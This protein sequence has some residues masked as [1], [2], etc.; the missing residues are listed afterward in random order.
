LQFILIRILNN[1]KEKGLRSVTVTNLNKDFSRLPRK[2]ELTQLRLMH[3]SVRALIRNSQKDM[4]PLLSL[5]SGTVLKLI[6]D[7]SDVY[8]KAIQ[9]LITEKLW[10]E[11]IRV[12]EESH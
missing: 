9:R 2:H 6:P 8:T 1:F 5:D 4:A 12:S 7:L 11:I 10:K 3:G